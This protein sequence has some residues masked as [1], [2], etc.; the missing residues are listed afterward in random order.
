[1]PYHI[2]GYTQGTGSGPDGNYAFDI[3]LD[4]GINTKYLDFAGNDRLA[5]SSTTND[6]VRIYDKTNGTWGLTDTISTPG[7]DGFGQGL[8]INHAGDRIV[9]GALDGGAPT[10]VVYFIEHD[11]NSWSDVAT[12]TSGSLGT[13]DPYYP[14]NVFMNAA[15]DVA[16]AHTRYWQQANNSYVGIVHVYKRTGGTWQ[17]DA[18]IEGS[19]PN[20]G[21]YAAISSDGTRV[22]MMS[23]HGRW[24]VFEDQGGGT[25]A[26]V[27]SQIDLTAAS[28]WA[29]TTGIPLRLTNNGT[30]VIIGEAFHDVTGN[31]NEGRV[32]VYDWN[33]SDWQETTIIAGT[34]TNEYLGSVINSTDDGSIIAIRRDDA[35]GL[36]DIYSSSLQYVKT[37][38][39]AGARFDRDIAFS[40]NGRTLAAI[41]VN[42]KDV[43]FF[44][45]V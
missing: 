13:G 5:V 27:G 24:R 39:E 11:G 29:Q 25:W 19:P 16:I 26:Q 21:E 7:V 41:D 30:R 23:Y 33:G 37:L 28:G 31:N 3:S 43:F 34:A 20:D 14:L 45:N 17:L 12:F 32:F 35:N 42:S 36:I 38:N 8:A 22:A 15:G 44:E 40:Q 6:T 2:L 10:G 4:T 9:V 18:A 1:M